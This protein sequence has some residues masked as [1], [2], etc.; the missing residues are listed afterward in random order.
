MLEQLQ[1]NARHSLHGLRTALF[2]N[3]PD[4]RTN[5]I[6][7]NKDA[8]SLILTLD[9]TKRYDE[10]I[11][12]MREVYEDIANRN[13]D[14]SKFNNDED[15]KNRYQSIIKHV[16]DLNNQSRLKKFYLI[17]DNEEFEINAE[18]RKYLKQQ[19]SEIYRE[20]MRIEGLYEGYKKGSNSFEIS[21]RQ[22]GKY[23]C[24]LNELEKSNYEKYSQIID[25]L[26]WINAVTSNVN[27][28]VIGTRIKP[29]TIEVE[30]LE[31]LDN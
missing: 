6:Y 21:V 9:A 11:S 10:P 18:S 25:I 5:D 28:R 20:E 24:H 2:A 15:K 22:K 4:Y 12:F 19:S 13:I 27:V 30:D 7:I 14:P 31:R 16:C 26:S 3:N 23:Y 29:K 8:G 17:I 1:Y